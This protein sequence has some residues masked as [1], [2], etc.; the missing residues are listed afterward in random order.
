MYSPSLQHQLVGANI[1]ELHRS[2]HPSTA[3]PIATMAGTAI[4]RRRRLR[5]SIYFWPVIDRFVGHAA[6][7]AYAF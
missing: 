6:R 7:E 4:R 5:R 1:Q 3:Q 2:C